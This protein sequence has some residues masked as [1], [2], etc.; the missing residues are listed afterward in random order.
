MKALSDLLNEREKNSTDL[1]DDFNKLFE[2]DKAL[3]KSI[4]ECENLESGEY[5]FDDCGMLCYGV[6]MDSDRDYSDCIDE[7]RGYILDGSLLYL[8][9]DSGEPILASTCGDEF[10]AIQSEGRLGSETVCYSSGEQVAKLNQDSENPWDD[11]YK[12]INDHMESQGC[13]PEVISVDDHG[14]VTL[15][16]DFYDWL[17][18]HNEK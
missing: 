2:S 10:Y 15:D 3:E 13:F 6:V 17:K 11:F 7:L 1:Q 8:N 14:G 9:L 4:K 18:K 5:F 16:S 12:E